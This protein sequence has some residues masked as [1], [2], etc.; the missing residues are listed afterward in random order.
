MSIGRDKLVDLAMSRLDSDKVG[1][2][3][4]GV[5]VGVLATEAAGNLTSHF[6]STSMSQVQTLNQL[7]DL[8]Y[9]EKSAAAQSVITAS[10]KMHSILGKIGEAVAS[11]V[12][13]V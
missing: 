10:A 13:S 11:Q 4:G 7:K 5:M 8:G 9:D 3:L 2:K 1:D 6:N 12:S